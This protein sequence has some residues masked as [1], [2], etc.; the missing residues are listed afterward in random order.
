MGGEEVGKV[1]KAKLQKKYQ[2]VVAKATK[3]LVA[4]LIEAKKAECD[5][6]NASLEVVI[7]RCG[8]KGSATSVV[9]KLLMKKRLPRKS[10]LRNRPCSNYHQLCSE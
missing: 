2:A 10:W 9:R 8:T 7:K 6:A 5:A 4:T 1:E 3:N